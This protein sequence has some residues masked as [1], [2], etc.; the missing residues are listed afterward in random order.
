MAYGPIRAVRDVDLRVAPGEVVALI[1]ANGAGKSTTLRTI[2]GLLRPAGGS[3]RFDDAEVAGARPHRLVRQGLV[4]VPEGRGILT[5]LSVLDNLLLGATTR[6]DRREVAA[7]LERAYARFPTLGERQDQSAGTLS[8]GEQQMLAIARALMARPRLLML[9]EP[10]LGLAPLVVREIFAAIA[11]LKASGVT[12]L[13][14]EQN[15]RA[16]LE[17]ADRGYVLETGRVAIT[18]PASELLTSDQVVRA[19]LGELAEAG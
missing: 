17:I 4:L 11:D 15:A 6:R 16:A 18:G 7:D 19:Y 10:S 9:D 5:R 8:G 2:A 14:V 1:G 12:I 13:L 3:I